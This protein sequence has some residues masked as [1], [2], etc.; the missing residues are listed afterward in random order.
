MND[1]MNDRKSKIDR[2][3]AKFGGAILKR[4]NRNSPFEY[5]KEEKSTDQ[6]SH[7][8]ERPLLEI[9]K[10]VDHRRPGIHSR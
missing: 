10:V 2:G 6:Y 1:Q 4:K 5:P 7:S 3:V 8:F 9:L